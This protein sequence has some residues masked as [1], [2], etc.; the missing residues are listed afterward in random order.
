[1]KKSR[2]LIKIAIMALSS[3]LTV[4][5]FACTDIFFHRNQYSVVARTMDFPRDTGNKMGL[6]VKG[7]ANEANLNLTYNKSAQP[8][9]WKNR[10]Y[11]IGQTWGHGPYVLDG[12]N[13]QGLYFGGLY[14]A[15]PTQYPEYDPHDARKVIGLADIGN[16]ILGT[17]KT[18]KQAVAE[19][20]AVQIVKNAVPS[21]F[22]SPNLAIVTPVHA[23]IHD[24]SGDSA[25]I[26]FVDGKVKIYHPAGPVLTNT[27]GYDWQLEHAK[28]FNFVSKKVSRKK[29]DG[30]YLEGSGFYGLPGDWTSASRFVRAVQILN[31]TPNPTSRDDAYALAMSALQSVQAPVGTSQSPTIW[32]S[33]SDLDKNLYFFKPM[34]HVVQK[35]V[36]EHQQYQAVNPMGE[37]KM[38]DLNHIVEQYQEKK[39]L[40]RGWVETVVK[41][42]KKAVVLDI[43][44]LLPEPGEE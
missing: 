30:Y 3:L 9:H 27:P 34:Y 23:V 25:V 29:F 26:E 31:H 36:P 1:M 2:L 21:D 44:N 12:I 19:L 17:A 37:W 20:Q 43:T 13:S 40:P 38:Y 28:K 22:I 5:A 35:G 18:V 10:Y 14:L 11:Y 7:E 16:Y 15:G 39:H 41:P 6:G 8:L 24:R 32:E 42:A 33:V 4:A